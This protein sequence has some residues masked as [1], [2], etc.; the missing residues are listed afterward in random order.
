[1]AI[2]LIYKIPHETKYHRKKKNDKTNKMWIDVK[3]QKE[4]RKKERKV[5]CGWGG[6]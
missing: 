5:D 2:R 6:T 4:K 3:K 1:M